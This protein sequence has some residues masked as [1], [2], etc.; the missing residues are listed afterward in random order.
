M[1]RFYTLCTNLS[2]IINNYNEL[3]N[4]YNAKFP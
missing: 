2:K 1:Y 3:R 4:L